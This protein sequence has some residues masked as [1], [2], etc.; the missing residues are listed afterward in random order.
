MRNLSPWPMLAMLLLGI[1]FL[2]E[3]RF[4]RAEENFLRW[5]LQNS[6]ARGDAVPLTVIEI[7]RN[8]LEQKQVGEKQS[9][10][11]FLHGGGSAISPLEYALFLQ[12]VL[13]FQPTVVAFENI[14]K[15]RTRDNDQEQVFLDQAMRVPKL[16]LGAELTDAPDPDAPVFEMTTFKQVSGRRGELPEFSGIGRQPGE[17]MR[18]IS[19]LGF[20][21]LLEGPNTFHVPLLFQY[22]GDVIPSFSLQALMLWLRV[23]PAE[24][25]IELGSQILLPQGRRIPIRADGTVLVDPK[26][27]RKAR[28]MTLNELLL[29]TQT[30]GEN[31]VTTAHLENIHDQIVLAR[32]PSNPFSPPDVFAATIATIQSNHYVRRVSRIFDCAVILAVTALAGML[33]RVS[34]D[35]LVLGAIALTA[36]YCLVALAIISRWGVWIPGYLPLGAIWLIVLLNLFPRQKKAAREDTP[37]HP[38][39]TP[40]PIG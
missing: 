39:V 12:S 38:S 23:T 34:K 24:V 22:R 20:M 36:A 35:I 18:L 27:A 10:E 2:R 3:P 9:T 37:D 30:R 28:R 8:P 15:W 13:E 16:L 21:N 7:G 33:Q 32:T 5:L 26:A 1:L 40:T 25:K 11:A 14:L 19:T 29:A 17:D 6:Q 31:G 4:Q